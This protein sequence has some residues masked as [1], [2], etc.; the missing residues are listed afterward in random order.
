MILI[1]F[2]KQIR[3]DKINKMDK[4]HSGFHMQK[5]TITHIYILKQK[6]KDAQELYK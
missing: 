3:N 6:G 4:L 1:L 2:S 5:D